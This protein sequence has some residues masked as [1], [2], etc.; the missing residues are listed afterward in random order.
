MPRPTSIDL[1]AGCGGLS[2]GLHQVGFEHLFAIEKDPMAFETFE[3]NFLAP[4]APYKSFAQWPFWLERRPHDIEEMLRDSFLRQCLTSL[5]GRVDLVCGGPPCQGFSVGG[6]RDG[7][8]HRNTLPQRYLDFVR[9]VRPRTVILENVEG[10]TRSF[11]ARPGEC[12]ISYADWL[13][14]QLQEIGYNAEFRVLNASHFGVP[15]TRM[16][17]IIFGFLKNAFSQDA[18]PARLFEFLSRGTGRFLASKGLPTDRPVTVREALDDLN[19]ERRAVCPDS[20]SFASGTYT[21][22]HSQYAVM[23]RR[24]VPDTAIPNS[25]RFSEHKAETLAFYRRVQTTQ[26]HG[27]LSKEFL[28]ANGMQKD[29]KVWIDPEVP[30]STITTHPDEF[31]H[32]D[33]PRIVTVREMARLQSFPDDFV[34][35]GRYTINGDRRGLDVARC[36]QVGNAV[37][38]LFGEAVGLAVKEFLNTCRRRDVATQVPQPILQ[39]AQ[40]TL[41]TAEAQI[42]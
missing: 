18:T 41:F 6:I 16:R 26:R 17:V 34:F 39:I 19:G 33:H 32:Y 1:F 37:P 22:P 12:A 5:R 28:R 9:L 15:Q 40:A 29:K 8:D 20:P 3:A 4:E 11:V 2:L 30:A 38:P 13:V 14:N 25:H 31:I 42:T 24:G 21:T 35:K 10:M 23:L 7:Q 27:R 36:V